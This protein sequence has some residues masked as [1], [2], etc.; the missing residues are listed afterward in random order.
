MLFAMTN[1]DMSDEWRKKNES[2]LDMATMVD[3]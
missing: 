1:R 3:I 2:D